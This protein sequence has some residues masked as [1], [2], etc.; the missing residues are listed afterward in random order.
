MGS[1]KMNVG[2][3]DGHVALMDDSESANPHIWLPTGTTLIRED[4]FPDVYEDYFGESSY[5]TI[6]DCVPAGR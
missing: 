4:L 1:Y 2:F 3:F 5:I 6:G